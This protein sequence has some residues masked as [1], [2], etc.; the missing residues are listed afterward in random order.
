[1]S[2]ASFINQEPCETRKDP[3]FRMEP[4]RAFQTHRDQTK[5]IWTIF[6]PLLRTLLI[7]RN[8]NLVPNNPIL[9]YN[10]KIGPNRES[11][12]PKGPI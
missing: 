8:T 10:E 2:T 4:I 6:G 3:I 5:P 1:M 7:P 11:F 12:G 9:T